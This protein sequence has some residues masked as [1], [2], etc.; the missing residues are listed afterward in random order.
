MR[1][2]NIHYSGLG[3]LAAVVNNL[4]TAA[5]AS[6]HEWL[7]GYYGVAPLDDAHVSFCEEHGLPYASFHP[8][9]RWP[10]AAWWALVQW[11]GEVRPDVILCHSST[12]IPAAAWHARRR[13]IPL[14]AVE[15]T[16]N[17]I[18]SRTEWA[19]S[20][21]AMLFADR[22]V[23]L[24][25]TYANLLRASLGRGF[26][27]RKINVIPNGV[28][29]E[30]FSPHEYPKL[31]KTLCAGMA[32]RLAPTKRH[33]LLIDLAPRIGVELEFAGDGESMTKLRTL[34]K[35]QSGTSVRFRGVV[36]PKEIPDWFRGLDLYLHASDGETFSMSV[37]QAMASGLPIIASEVSGMDEIL[38]KD[39]SCG[40][41]V[42][43]EAEAWY[44]AI[45]SLATDQKLRLKL[46]QAARSR[47]VSK[48]S[49]NAMLENYLQLINELTTLQ[50]D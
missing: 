37:L 44:T 21:A 9:P 18:K 34:A 8:R 7:M 35:E 27:E 31:A 10:W 36:P 14:V 5:G 38:G 16:P 4:V 50:T 11:L 3:G 33:D 40:W 43:N 48:F 6:S 28:D 32:A 41:L 30:L 2:V 12:A 20:Y 19:A 13:R 45:K 29:V 1:I 47:A 25:E 15:H 39:G 22:V 49:A 26:L 24:T 17:E 42:P 23:V 46:G